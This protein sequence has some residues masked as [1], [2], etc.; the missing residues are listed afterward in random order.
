MGQQQEKIGELEKH[1][2]YL[3]QQARIFN[4]ILSTINDYVYNFDQNGRF[5][6]ANQILLDFFDLEAKDVI[7]KTMAELNYPKDV[8]TVLLEGIRQVFDTKQIIVNE[9]LFMMPDGTRRYAENILNPFLADDGS[10]EFVVGSTRNITNHKLAEQALRE[11]EE[12]SRLLIEGATDFAIFSITPDNLIA[13]WNTGAERVFGYKESE[14]IGQSGEILFT[15]EDREKGIPKKEMDTARNEGRAEDERWHLRKDG[16]RFFASGLM[17]RLKEGAHGFVKITRDMTKKLEA[18][19]A[20]REKEL[21]Q[22]LVKAQEDERRRIARDLHDELGQQL[23]ALRLKLESIRK[24]CEKDD[25]LSAKVDDVQTIAKHIDNGVDFLAWELRPSVL[26]DWGLIAALDKY[27]REW[28]HYAGVT[29]EFIKP[30][31]KRMPLASEVEINLYRIVQEA[32][33]NTHKHAKANRVG[34]MLDKRDDLI[35]LII[36]DDGIGFNP[37]NKKTR[38]KGLGLIGMQE[39][40]ALINGTVEI[41]STLKKGTTIYVRIP[42]NK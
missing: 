12:R 17:M 16:M 18:E 27:V 28:S 40:A 22:K 5:L 23:T 11:S 37:K 32:L 15:A 39:R 35:V 30:D 14:I 13:S 1:I 34:M 3:K 6:Y 42:A 31:N 7:G 19:K 9:T 10:V 29:A 25:E 26:D 8:E 2:G 41:E 38:S 36:E 21:L 4:T 20:M 24:L 33:N